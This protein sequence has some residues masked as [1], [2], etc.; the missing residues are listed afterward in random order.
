M[1]LIFVELT[2]IHTSNTPRLLSMSDKA[3]SWEKYIQSVRSDGK[4]CWVLLENR[5][6]ISFNKNPDLNFFISGVGVNIAYHCNA[7]LSNSLLGTIS[8]SAHDGKL[9][10]THTHLLTYFIKSQTDVNSFMTRTD[11]FSISR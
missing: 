10:E 8:S 9:E 2:K 5:F 4:I 6:K 1:F 7:S 3:T 11:N